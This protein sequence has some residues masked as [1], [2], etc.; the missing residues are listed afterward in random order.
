MRYL[1]RAS[2][3]IVSLS[4][5]LELI[6]P[7][8]SSI[9]TAF[10]LEPTDSLKLAMELHDR[11]HFPSNRDSFPPQFKPFRSLIF[12]PLVFLH[13]LPRLPQGCSPNPPIL[14]LYFHII[15]SVTL[16]KLPVLSLSSIGI[17]FF[18]VST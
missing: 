11:G 17:Q 1:E 18:T 10:L 14:L 5:F 4:L 6:V 13:F 12:A 15:G 16:P 2:P 8:P 9:A 7:K 3:I